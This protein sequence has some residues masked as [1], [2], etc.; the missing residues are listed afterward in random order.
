MNPGRTRTDSTYRMEHLCTIVRAILYGPLCASEFILHLCALRYAFKCSP[1]QFGEGRKNQSRSGDRQS[2][3]KKALKKPGKNTHTFAPGPKNTNWKP[4]SVK[5]AKNQ[6][7]YE[8]E[9]GIYVA[10]AKCIRLTVGRWF[11][12]RNM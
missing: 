11:T 7:K 9:R 6:K 3:P 8:R 1:W 10:L 5:T 12:M 4:G 2:A